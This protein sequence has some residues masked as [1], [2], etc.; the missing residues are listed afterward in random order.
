MLSNNEVMKQVEKEGYA[1]L[2]VVELDKINE[3]EIK[4]KRIKEY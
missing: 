4:K 2:T 1:Y 3:D